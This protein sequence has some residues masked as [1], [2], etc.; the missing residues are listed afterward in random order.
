MHCP[1]P[2]G[3]GWELYQ[4]VL[5]DLRSYDYFIQTIEIPLHLTFLLLRTL[6]YP[7]PQEDPAI[8]F[9][10]SNAG[11]IVRQVCS[12]MSS[13]SDWFHRKTTS[14]IYLS[15]FTFHRAVLEAPEKHS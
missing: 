5:I 10:V 1:E 8:Y 15:V 3:S 11:L 9:F 2:E 12:I 6:F 7:R 13:Q 14:I 4:R